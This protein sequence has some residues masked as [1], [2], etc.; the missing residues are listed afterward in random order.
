M[1]QGNVDLTFRV[2]GHKGKGSRYYEKRVN[3]RPVDSGT[4]YF[5]SIRRAKG[6]PFTIRVSL[7][8]PAPPSQLTC[9]SNPSP[10]PNYQRRW[11]GR[12]Y[13]NHTTHKPTSPVVAVGLRCG[14]PPFV[15][16]YPKLLFADNAH[17]FTALHS[18]LLFQSSLHFLG[19]LLLSLL[20]RL[21]AKDFSAK[22]IPIGGI[23]QQRS[24][25]NPPDSRVSLL[26][27][28]FVSVSSSI[29]VPEFSTTWSA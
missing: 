8:H 9:D 14:L 15:H 4:V 27:S 13:P 29:R 17:T 25:T 11:T 19:A 3:S 6:E 12:Q 16:F 10:F 26:I 21:H 22:K 20:S 23:S 5:T 7:S 24:H 2:K 1:P 28:N 18:H